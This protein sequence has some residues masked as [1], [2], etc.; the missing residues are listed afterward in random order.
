[1]HAC[2]HVRITQCST[3]TS[4]LHHLLV[5][6][7]HL[8]LQWEPHSVSWGM[9]V[10]RAGLKRVELHVYKGGESQYPTLRQTNNTLYE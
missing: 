1:M 9:M 3:H 2:T 4:H 8:Q 5:Q 10:L 7:V 6:L